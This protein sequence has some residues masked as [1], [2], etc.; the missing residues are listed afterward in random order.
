VKIDAAG[1]RQLQEITPAKAFFA[2]VFSAIT[3]V[4]EQSNRKLR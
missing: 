1:R 4:N 2:D 3:G